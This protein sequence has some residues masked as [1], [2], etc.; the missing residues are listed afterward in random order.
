MYIKSQRVANIPPYL[1]SE[2]NRKKQ[3][4]IE[5]GVD[6][7]D[8]GIGCPDLPTPAHIIERLLEEMKDPNNFKYS[9]YSGCQEFREAVAKFYKKQF[10]VDLDPETEILTLIGSKEG[11][12]HFISASIDPGDFVLLPDPGYP[13][14]RTATF[15]ANGFPYSMPLL[16]GNQ[17]LPDFSI[18]PSH[19]KEKAKIMFLNYPSN[20][21]AAVA[22]HEFFQEAVDFSRE[23]QITIAHDA[24]YQMVTFDGY[25]SPSILQAEG[26][27]EV[28]VEFGSLSKTYSMTGWRIGYA[29][30][31]RDALK[32]LSVVKSNVDTSQF[33]PIQKAAATALTDDQ[34]CI[35]EYNEIYKQRRKWMLKA[36]QELGIEAD[37]P[38]GSFF[39]WATVP[40]VF[41]SSEFVKNVLEKTGVIVTPG[42]AFGEYGEGYFRISLSVPTERLQQAID[43]IRSKLVLSV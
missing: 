7:I 14:Y 25:Q 10:N 23:N 24:A 41:S 28:A 16:R 27:R 11:I 33:I 12:A 4:L 3:E 38:K 6:V 42:T 8:L 15:L 43:R 5:Q 20:P 39:I 1:F 34:T 37:S 35:A 18:I 19:I 29:V 36:L 22:G 21:T 13:T 17:Y 31:N 32:S 26:A 2:I 9:G 40:K 30:G